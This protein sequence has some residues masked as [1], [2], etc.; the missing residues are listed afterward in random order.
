MSPLEWGILLFIPAVVISPA[1]RY[2]PPQKKEHIVPGSL[3][4]GCSDL[5]S[6]GIEPEGKAPAAP[7]E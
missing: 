3:C 1:W 6:L 4:C 2:P 5:R 7:Q